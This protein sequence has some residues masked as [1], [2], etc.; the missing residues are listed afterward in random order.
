MYLT[1]GVTTENI[2]LWLFQ[3]FCN[4]AYMSLLFLNLNNLDL[5]CRFS[6]EEIKRMYGS[7]KE[8]GIHAQ[9]QKKRHFAN[10]S[11]DF[12]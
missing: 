1:P 2:C 3:D 12:H 11:L 8:R 4:M 10:I 6:H 5:R 9:C 7:F